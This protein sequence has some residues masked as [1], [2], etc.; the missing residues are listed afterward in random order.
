M[1]YLKWALLVPGQII[2]TLL[3]LILAP[4]LPA[5]ANDGW[6]PKYLSWFQT[7][8]NSL[9]GDAGWQ[10][11]FVG[12]TNRYLR[13]VLWLLRNPAYGFDR[14]VLGYKVKE[15]ILPEIIGDNAVSNIPLHTGRVIRLYREQD[16]ITCFQF[17]LIKSYNLFGLRCIRL[18]F[19]WK[20]W[21]AGKAGDIKQLVCSVNP[22]M[23]IQ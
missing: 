18:H 20:I 12:I 13:Q 10:N 19:G 8:D 4:V 6:L 1:I 22:W 16:K 23:K 15:F 9:D 21:G 17:Y 7:P 5:F 3:S 14:N 11:H 2:I